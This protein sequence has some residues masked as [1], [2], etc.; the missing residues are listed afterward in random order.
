MTPSLEPATADDAP[1][2][3]DLHGR[4]AERL[5]ALH[6]VGHWSHRPTAGSVLR[7]M[8][9]SRVYVLRDPAIVATLRLTTKKPWAIDP[10]PFT[11]AGKKRAVYLLGMAVDPDRQRAG[12]GR[13]CL[14]A[15]PEL[16]R[17]WPAD[18]IRLDAYDAPAGAG[19]FY[20]S[21]GY[22]EVGRVTYRT[23]PLIYYEYVL[24]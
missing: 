13:R 3:V 22:R 6:G 2:L 5:T 12:L 4:V 1:A 14:A 10:A 24:G 19:G 23:V 7:A 16:A 21:C 11:P 15:V 20:A 8:V 9:E 18:V 17:G